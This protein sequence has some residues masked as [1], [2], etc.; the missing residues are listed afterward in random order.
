MARPAFLT[1]KFHDTPPQFNSVERQRHLYIDTAFEEDVLSKVRGSAN[2]AYISLAYCYFKVSSQFFDTV[3][4]KD[5]HYLGR[6]FSLPQNNLNWDNYHRDTRNN[7]KELILEFLGYKHFDDKNS[8]NLIVNFVERYARVQKSFKECFYQVAVKLRKEKIVIPSYSKLERL[9][10]ETYSIHE[11]K[12]FKVVDSGLKDKDKRLLDKLFD[13]DLKE[14]SR[15]GQYK[16]TLLKRF[17]QSLQPEK[18][19]SNIAAFDV[20]YELFMIAYPIVKKLDLSSEGIRHYATSVH[21]N[22][23]FQIKRRK[24]SNRYLHLLT[25]VTHQFYQLQDVLVETLI[26]A[27]TAAYNTAQKEVREYYYNIRNEQ[28]NNTSQLVNRSESM[29]ETLESVKA[30]LMDQSLDDAVKV[31]K[32]L[33]L[34][35]PKNNPTDSV[36]D[37]IDDVKKDLD[38]MSGE[39]LFYQF[40]EKG[41]VK[42]QRRCNDI[43]KRLEFSEQTSNKSLISAINRFKDKKGK[44]DGTFPV[45]F[46]KSNEKRYIDTK[47]EFKSKLYKV[48]L[49]NHIK[50]SLKGDALSLIHSYR[51][52]CLDQYLIPLNR[53][54]K[55]KA[56]LLRQADMTQYANFKDVITNLELDLHQQYQE[57]NEHILEKNNNDVKTDDFGGYRL[58]YQRNTAYEQ[59]LINEADIEL[60]PKKNFVTLS[61]VLNT[62]HHASGFLNEFQHHSNKYLKERPEN[63]TFIAATIG[64]G[65]HFSTP[66]FAKLSRSLNN[67]ALITTA[68]N[69]MSVENSRQACNSILKFVA[70]MPLANLFIGD[71]GLQTSSDGQKW[72]VAYE[73]LNANYSFKYGGKDLVVSAYSFIDCRNFFFHSE[74]ISGAER[75]AHYMIDGVLQNNVVKSDLHSTDTHGYTEMVFGASHL[76][77]ISFAPRIKKVHKQYLYSLKSKSS[78][79]R[80]NYPILP[81]DRIKIRLIEKYWDEILRLLVSIKLG[82][83]TASQVFK[84]LNSY[85]KNDNPLYLALKEFGRI[86]KSHY[87]LRF[88]DDPELRSAV[89]KQLN[90]SE[91]GNKLDKALAIGRSD[92]VQTTKEEQEAVESCKRVIKNAIVCWNYMY[93]TQK[94]M[95]T[96]SK[97]EK[98]ALL[99]K[100]KSCSTVTWEHLLIHG[101]FDFSD[102]TLK[103]SRSFNYEKMQD[104][105]ILKF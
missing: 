62:V 42:L 65:C 51:Y 50:D 101:S 53:W 59:V 32:A 75:E 93:L 57:T 67:A 103:D 21:K 83:T 84:R 23:V 63:K 73:S 48:V 30:T 43:V 37:V 97:V 17:S 4:S 71:H 87:I 79:S 31:K 56:K 35:S 16:L 60:Y 5:L 9:V 94:L 85:S 22:Q 39:A 26:S 89:Q 28:A 58:N 64:I 20:L 86:I 74:V 104:P 69:Y 13:K 49:F 80:L 44:V 81:K 96:K 2:K 105:N 18:I 27:V 29:L 88:I 95:T 102:S 100:I 19:S 82:E 41:S 3:Y 15:E 46:L 91:S 10:L 52:K 77:N 1:Q 70:K 45:R 11:K 72:T 54:E 40:L 47:D 55:D 7:H 25:F 78:Y 98:Q 6:T 36:V 14:G 33:R 99:N 90:K 24:D 34:L 66:Q 61:E 68:N 8:Q 92:Y 38:R 12:L 76:L